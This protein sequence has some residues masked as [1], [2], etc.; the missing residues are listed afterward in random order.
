M[1]RRPGSAYT[2]L[3]TGRRLSLFLLHLSNLITTEPAVLSQGLAAASW[4]CPIG[5]IG[6]ASVQMLLPL[7]TR[8]QEPLPQ[9]VSTNHRKW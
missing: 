6:N 1:K 4:S 2:L 7:P 8:L 9:R 3:I 5:L